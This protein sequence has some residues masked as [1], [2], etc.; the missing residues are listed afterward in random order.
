MNF[1]NEELLVLGY[2]EFGEIAYRTNKS[3][4]EFIMRGNKTGVDKRKLCSYY[5][6][7]IRKLMN[8]YGL[9]TDMA[10]DIILKGVDK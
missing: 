4:Y 2:M 6:S 10:K 8:N 9:K 5:E 7:I 3:S 1:T